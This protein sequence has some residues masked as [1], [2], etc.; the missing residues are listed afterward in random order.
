MNSKF[1][2]HRGAMASYWEV[3]VIA[4]RRMTALAQRINEPRSRARLMVLAAFHRAHASR[5]LAR[6]AALGRGPL[7]VPNQ[8]VTM[9]GTVEQEFSHIIGL[10]EVLS[11]RYVRTAEACRMGADLSSA[12]VCELNRTEALDAIRELKSLQPALQE[13]GT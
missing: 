10:N 8:E 4:A 7:P 6:L 3:E 13:V 1:Q 5:L 11:E 9:E 2:K 12:W